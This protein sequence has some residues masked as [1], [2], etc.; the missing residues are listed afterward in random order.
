MPSVVLVQNFEYFITRK[1]SKGSQQ[2][3]CSAADVPEEVENENVDEDSEERNN[4]GQ[5]G[6]PDDSFSSGATDGGQQNDCK[7]G[8]ENDQ[9]SQRD[10]QQEQESADVEEPE[11][12]PINEEDFEEGGDDGHSGSG[13]S[14]GGSQPGSQQLDPGDFD[15]VSNSQS[16]A[17]SDGSIGPSYNPSLPSFS[18]NRLGDVGEISMQ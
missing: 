11:V 5:G 18:P 3:D 15:V 1:M 12:V 16:S 14:S 13:S 2:Q 17:A 4:Q 10:S 8:G 7:E 6:H 9:A